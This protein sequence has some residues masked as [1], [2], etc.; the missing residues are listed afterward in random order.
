MSAASDRFLQGLLEYN[1]DLGDIDIRFNHIL[2]LYDLMLHAK[3]SEIVSKLFTQGCR[4][5]ASVILIPQNSLPKRKFNIDISRNAQHMDLSKSPADIKEIGII[6]QRTL[7]KEHN[8]SK[9]I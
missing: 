6:S 2:V 9:S 1:D 7:L 8:K 5:N 4:R 3:D